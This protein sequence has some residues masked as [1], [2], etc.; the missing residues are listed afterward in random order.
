MIHST[1]SLFGATPFTGDMYPFIEDI[2]W[3]CWPSYRR[4][5]LADGGDFEAAFTFSAIDEILENW[6]ESRIGTRFVE[7]C[8]GHTA[9]V[10]RLERMIL[11]YNDKVLSR[12]LA[13][14]YNSIRVRY[15]TS[16][17][18]SKAVTSASTDSDSIAK[19]GTREL[20]VDADVYLSATSAGVYADNLL[21]RLKEPRIHSDTVKVID[22]RQ[23]GQLQV[24]VRGYV[25]TL[26][27]QLHY[28][29]STSDDD[30][31]DEVQ[32]ALSGADFVTEGTIDANTLQVKEEADYVPVWTRIRN[33]AALGDSGG[34]EWQA[35]CYRSQQLDYKQRDMD[36]IVYY[37]QKKANRRLTLV[38]D[39]N[40]FEVPPP[41]VQPGV[42]AF[43]SDIMPG[44]PVA[45]PLI[46]DPRAIFI[47]RVTYDQ[48]GV[49]LDG[50]NP[51]V[52]NAAFQIALDYY[53]NAPPDQV[54]NKGVDPFWKRPR[55]V[56]MVPSQGGG[57]PF[58]R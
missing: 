25:Q 43:S 27:A 36:T 46:D 50:L 7:V 55:R 29:A 16:S 17:A 39:T 24:T 18:V 37:I 35:G 45:S 11:T 12:D 58:R 41:L 5:S 2:T 26:K 15:Q 21:A 34:N 23:P 32:D 54:V 57:D 47:A 42:I 13:E 9:F 10:G 38:E 3:A 19:Y 22:D 40:G 30:A 56:G 33:I 4:A 53:L 14:V 8:E 31:D 44:L 48:D 20:L 51:N 1:M 28:S 6:F 49:V 52:R